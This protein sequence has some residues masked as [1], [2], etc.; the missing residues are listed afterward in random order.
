M[1]RVLHLL[2]CALVAAG[3]AA[4]GDGGVPDSQQPAVNRSPI[5]N[6]GTARTV[7]VGTQVTLDGSASSDP[8]GDPLSFSWMVTSSPGGSTAML[9]NAS[10]SRP[11]LTPDR[12]GTYAVRLVVSDGRGAASDDTVT[13]TAT[14]V[15][16]LAIVLDQAEPLSGTVKLSLTGTVS[17]GVTWYVDLR[18]IGDGNAADAG[19]IA[20]NTTGVSN[21]EHQVLARIQTGAGT[22]Q[23]VRRSVTVSNSTVGLSAS[24]SGTTGTINVDV[25]ASSAFGITSVAA[26][27]DGLAIGTLTEPNACS[28]YCTGTND[29]YRFTVDAADVGSGPHTMVITATDRSGSARSLTVDVPVSNAPVLALAEPADGAFVFGSLRVAGTVTSDKGGAVATTARLGDVEFL[30]TQASSFAGSYDLTGL[31]PGTYTLT[32]SSTDSTG[33]SSQVQRTVVVT[34]SASLAY[35]PVF[36]LPSAGELLAAE[37]TRVLYAAGDG[38]IA[39]RDLVANSEVLLGSVS[40]LQYA[41]DWQLSGGRVYAQAKDSDC[42]P[43]FTCIYEWNAAGVRRNLSLLSPYTTGS[44][45]QVNPVARDG[46][47]V[48]TNWQGPSPG[49]YTL[50]EVATQLFTRVAQPTEVN[51]VGNTDYGLAVIGGGVHFAFWGQTGGEGTTSQFDVFLWRSDTGISTRITSGGSRNIYPMIDATR[52]A[53]RQ[54]PVGGSADGT[55]FLQT[56]TLANGITATLS[57]K[58]TVFQLLDGVLAWVEMPT[59]DSRALKAATTTI[60][61]TLSTLNTARLYA[62]GGGVVVFG[63]AGKVYTWSSATGVR[64]LRVDT[65][66]SSVFMTGGALVFAVN[67]S[68]YRVPL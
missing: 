65:A 38:G 62:T 56:L 63:E 48:W 4:C 45:Y 9:S 5:A 50:F 7:V 20:W 2:A 22:F 60:T 40:T 25:R 52:M 23:E 8:D 66:P 28:R 67:G 44:A 6:A 41:T 16:P 46:Y 57:S 43:T 34:S 31:A 55:F 35:T 54:S 14:P 68:V 42:T 12:E 64:T 10:T 59:T 13:V 36:S 32:V 15:A 24:V 17:G 11:T 1:N 18:L 58:A 26:R 37:G 33:Q 29:V 47:V 53:W 3:L 27:F 51:Y 39:V 49:S 21:G 61:S 19:S 30:S